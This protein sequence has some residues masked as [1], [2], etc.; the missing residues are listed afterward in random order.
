MNFIKKI[1]GVLVV[2]TIMIPGIGFASD[3]ENNK[4]NLLFKIERNRD[5]DEIYYELNP[6]ETGRPDKKE[7]V[8]V[9]WVKHTQNG[10]TEPL[11]WIQKKYSYGIKTIDPEEEGID[12]TQKEN[13]CFRFVSFGECFFS[14]KPAS[15]GIYKAI[16]HHKNREIEVSGIFVQIE[17]D[18]FRMPSVPFVQL[19]GIDL[20]TGQSVTETIYP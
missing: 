3:S 8:K 7:P 4:N 5:A 20:A 9:Y 15:D 17:G 2:L 14:L 1:S 10:K 6:D 16:V 18:R 13:V 11:T 19:H 12:E